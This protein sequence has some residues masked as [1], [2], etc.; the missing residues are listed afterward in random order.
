MWAAADTGTVLGHTC[1]GRTTLCLAL[2]CIHLPLVGGRVDVDSTNA[3]GQAQAALAG[4]QDGYL[5]HGVQEGHPVV[6]P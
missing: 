6:C 5:Q 2:H 1:G 3:S 4:A